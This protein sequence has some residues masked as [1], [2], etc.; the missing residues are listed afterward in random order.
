M[1]VKLEYSRTDGEIVILEGKFGKRHIAKNGVEYFTFRCFD[2]R[3]GFRRIHPEK[4]ISI[5]GSTITN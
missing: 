2:N 1:M 4:I 3:D 5:M